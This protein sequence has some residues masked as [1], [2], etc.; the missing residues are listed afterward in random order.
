MEK[1]DLYSFL[2]II[3][4]FVW[5][6]I[7]VPLF[8]SN[9][10]NVAGIG[11]LVICLVGMIMVDEILKWQAASYTYVDAVCRPSNTRLHLFVKDLETQEIEPGVYATKLNLAQKVKHPFYQELEYLVI[12]HEL[13]WED[14][15]HFTKGKAVYKGI[16]VDHPKTAKI[17]LYEPYEG[18]FD[19]DHLSPIPVFW[20]KEAP[21][22][23]YLPT[24]ALASQALMV[25]GAGAESIFEL[26]NLALENEKLRSQVVELKR[27]ALDWHQKAVR[28]EEVVDQLKNELLAV[29]RSKA[30]FKAAVVEYM[31]TIREAQL[32]IENALKQL[33]GPRIA[34]TKALAVMVL[35]LAAIATLWFNPQ[36]LQWLSIREN[37][38]FVL[39]LAGIAGA[40]AYYIYKRR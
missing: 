25:N 16:V 32:K 27:Q 10:R 4:L 21:G 18:S 8:P 20:L 19:V 26:K 30:D 3:A 39:L 12:K 34:I 36:I 7:I 38:F 35:G 22:D 40:T 6:N 23:Y 31:L 2:W 24:E 11:G 13:T 29:L 1:S 9:I 28:L 14:R 33:R 17:I 37:Q 5:L 15:M